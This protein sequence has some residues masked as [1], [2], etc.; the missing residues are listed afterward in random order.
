M[1]RIIYAYRNASPDILHI[2]NGEEEILNVHTDE[3]ADCLSLRLDIKTSQTDTGAAITTKTISNPVGN[4]HT[5]TL[6]IEDTLYSISEAWC[7]IAAYYEGAS[8]ELDNVD[9]LYI[10]TVKIG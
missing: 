9:P 1:N 8:P 2:N 7:V 6:T 10:A 5:F 3:L 4:L